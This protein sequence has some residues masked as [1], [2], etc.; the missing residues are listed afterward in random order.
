MR[1]RLRRGGPLPRDDASTTP[2]FG[3]YRVLHQIGS[4]VLGP[5]FRAFDREADRLIAIKAFQL[6]VTPEVVARVASGLR[7]LAARPSPHSMIVVPMAA[8]LEGARAYIALPLVAGESLDARLRHAAPPGLD[9]GLRLLTAFAA[10]LDDAAAAGWRH[11]SLH[12]RDFLIDA[13]RG[14]S[15]ITGFGIGPVL[16]AAGVPAPLRR[17]YAA[18]E[19]LT[20]G[21]PWD[22][23]ADVYAFAAIAHEVLTGRRPVSTGEQDGA[24][25]LDVTPEQRVVLRQT[26][27]RALAANPADRFQTASEFVEWLDLVCGPLRRYVVDAPRPSDDAATVAAPEPPIPVVPPAPPPVADPI[28]AAPVA[29]AAVD[30]ALHAEAHPREVATSAGA[31]SAVRTSL[32]SFGDS[33][34]PAARPA[35]RIARAVIVTAAGVGLGAGL[36]YLVYAS[37][38]RPQ[39]AAAGPIAAPQTDTEVAL[40]S[41]ATGTVP[42]V[43]PRPATEPASRVMAVSGQLVVRSQPAGAIVR[44]DGALSG[45]TPATIRDLPLGTHVV[46]VARPGHEP[47]TDRVTLTSETPVQRVN[48]E[49]VRGLDLGVPVRGAIA[50]DSRPRGARVFI[51]GRYVGLTPLRW[52]DAALGAHQVVLDLAGYTR[53]M[54]PVTVRQGEPARVTATL[55]AASKDRE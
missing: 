36:G 50:V 35:R 12:P 17:A 3:P 46:Q 34:V 1:D 13:E 44:V 32:L 27:A 20:P 4:G 51:D 47:W 31:S 39:P 40:Q 53:T 23:R 22:A 49:L 33:A 52:P 29:P 41:E 24:F 2:A 8:G 55:V 25:G 6:D 18:P 19:R 21:A 38:T 10:A 45:E 11:G 54:I 28:I 5:V 43:E 7:T 37:R 30:I 14:Q 26:L 16:E 9:E 15:S 42:R 48:V